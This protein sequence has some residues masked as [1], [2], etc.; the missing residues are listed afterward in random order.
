VPLG[1]DATSRSWR[2]DARQTGD[3]HRDEAALFAARRNQT[4]ART[5]MTRFEK[6]GTARSVAFLR[7]N[8]AAPY[9]EAGHALSMLQLGAD[10]VRSPRRAPRQPDRYGYDANYLR[11]RIVGARLAAWPPSRRCSASSR[12]AR[13]VTSNT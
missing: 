1:T 3:R 9:H 8:A 12:A 6:L 7:P 11:G 13:K 10:P 2:P 4:G 5:S